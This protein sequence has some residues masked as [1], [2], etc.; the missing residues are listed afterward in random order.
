MP[1]ASV[2]PRRGSFSAGRQVFG[3]GVWQSETPAG[4]APARGRCFFGRLPCAD[5]LATAARRIRARTGGRAVTAPVVSA[6]LGRQRG[7]VGDDQARDRTCERDI[8]AAQTRPFVR[9]AVDD[10]LRLVEDHVVVLETLG[11]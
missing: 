11:E 3:Y 4:G 10:R 8:Q 2:A 6:Q 7:R 9:L 5:G 1:W